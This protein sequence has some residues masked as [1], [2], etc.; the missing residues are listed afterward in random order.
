MG[1]WLAILSLT[2]VSFAIAAFTLRLPR[3]GFA[4]F[5][6]VLLFGL[7]G[8]AWQGHPDQPGA[9]K[10]PDLSTDQE[11]G[12][13]MVTARRQL[14]DET[15]AK[16]DY[17]VLSDGF[18]RRGKFSDAAGLLRQ[19]LNDNPDHLEG[20]LAL[21]MALTGHADG[22]V[23]PAAFYAYG[24]ARELDPA[25]PGADFFLGISFQ[26]TGQFRAARDTWARLLANS[27][28]DAPWRPEIEA[29]VERLDQM[30]ANAPMLQ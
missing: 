29:R 3:E 13:G 6:A 17:L 18:A 28:E 2:L 21:G 8:Y 15:R 27:P 30:I 12:E 19:G 23:T 11:S 7:V 10:E 26:Q 25:N 16:P 20:W 9:P 22:V 24:K 14:F 5:G 4:V 1:G